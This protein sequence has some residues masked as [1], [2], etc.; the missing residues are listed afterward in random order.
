MTLWIKKRN[1]NRLDWLHFSFL[2][3]LCVVVGN[4]TLLSTLE[5]VSNCL[6]KPLTISY[7]WRHHPPRHNLRTIL[8]II[9]SF[10]FL[11]HSSRGPSNYSYPWVLSSPPT[12]DTSPHNAD[13]LLSPRTHSPHTLISGSSRKI[14]SSSHMVVSPHKRR[15]S[16][17]HLLSVSAC[18]IFM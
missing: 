10:N 3:V 4:G 15:R 9:L 13:L 1:P 14:S 17:S 16:P 12:Q 6:S 5:I 8:H 11:I 2:H 18:H 7:Q